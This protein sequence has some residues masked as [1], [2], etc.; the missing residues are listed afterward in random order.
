MVRED[1]FFTQYLENIRELPD[2]QDPSDEYLEKIFPYTTAEEA[3]DMLKEGF[4][5]APSIAKDP[6]RYLIIAGKFSLTFHGKKLSKLDCVGY[7]PSQPGENEVKGVPEAIAFAQK[8]WGEEYRR[9]NLEELERL[10]NEAARKGIKVTDGI[11]LV[12]NGR[13]P[14]MSKNHQLTIDQGPNLPELTLYAWTLHELL[15]LGEEKISEMT[16]NYAPLET[17]TPAIEKYEDGKENTENKPEE[18]YGTETAK[19]EDDNSVETHEEADDS[20]IGES[21]ESNSGFADSDPTDS[22]DSDYGGGDYD[23]GSFGD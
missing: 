3:R 12:E 1:D 14:R 22:E 13:S 18:K 9:K 15:E 6:E 16:G 5:A 2:R 7:G 17:Q 10:K 11:S 21:D 8:H 23:G 19:N 4:L 20:R